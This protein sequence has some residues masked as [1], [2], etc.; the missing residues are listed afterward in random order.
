[1][2]HI[3][4]NVYVPEGPQYP[5]SATPVVIETPN[6][7]VLFDCGMDA[8][9]RQREQHSVDGTCFDQIAGFS[10]RQAKP[11]SLIF[12]S[13]AHGDHT[14]DAPFY[15]R[16]FPEVRFLGHTQN[17]APLPRFAGLALH[18]TFDRD[19]SFYVD[20][21]ELRVLMT[22]GHTENGED[23]SLLIPAAGL[24]CTGD[25]VQPHGERYEQGEGTF[26]PFYV[27]GDDYLQSLQRLREL[28]P[29]LVQ[30]AHHGTYSGAL[31][32]E[33]SIRAVVR[34][35]DLASRL[36]RENPGVSDDTLAEWI[37]DTIGYE[38][39][40]P[41]DAVLRRRLGEQN[42]YLTYDIHGINYFIAKAR[43][44]QR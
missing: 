15:Q 22:P 21:V 3:A 6:R 25:T 19:A 9:L 11:V 36:L 4:P 28:N 1:M 18:Q 20:G 40:V 44:E 31:A 5:A 30:T 27:R 17:R 33:T 13:H 23:I 26:M 32:L 41:K 29:A 37:F 35:R 2:L 38:R 42:H 39:N 12:L 7:L 10:Q 14:L 43:A 16:R 24:V 8:S 34:T